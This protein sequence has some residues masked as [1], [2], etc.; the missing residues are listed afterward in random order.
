MKACR[1]HLSSQNVAY[2][3]RSFARPSAVHTFRHIRVPTVHALGVAPAGRVRF[4]SHTRPYRVHSRRGARR[5]VQF[6]SED[7]PYR[8]HFLA[9]PTRTT[10]AVHTSR[11]ERVPTVRTNGPEVCPVGSHPCRKVST[12]GA[13]FAVH[14]FRH[15]RVPT[16]HTNGPRAHGTRSS[17]MME[18]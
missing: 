2:R 4:P 15:E 3:V 9:S 1:V 6:P 18:L 14:T 5:R 8:A 12:V 17:C 16:A 13:F 10:R 11:H 7:G